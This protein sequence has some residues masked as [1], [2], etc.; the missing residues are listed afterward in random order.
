MRNRSLVA[1]ST[2][3]T[4]AALAVAAILPAP[5]G[6]ADFGGKTIE[7]VVPFPTA[8]GSDVWARFFAPLTRRGWM[9]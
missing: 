6:A 1:L 4:G 5:A 8:G 9:R 7:F 2:A 3:L